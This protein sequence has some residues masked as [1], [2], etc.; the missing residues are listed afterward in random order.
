MRRRER[1]PF[2]TSV[3]FTLVEV[4]V[5]VVVAAVVFVAFFGIQTLGLRTRVHARLASTALNAAADV[6][7][8]MLAV[9]AQ[10]PSG[11]GELLADSGFTEN[12]TPSGSDVVFFKRWEV[13]RGEPAA[14]L[15][16]VRVIL[17]WAEP[18]KPRPTAT[19]C[20]FPNPE[21][22]HVVLEG[23]AYRP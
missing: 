2:A 13:K 1:F 8:H 17:C 5:S 16:T 21:A 23:M 11:D 18:G 9:V 20:D 7:E 6:L 10:E 19:H 14:D 22:P 12:W 15:V 4:L 3:G